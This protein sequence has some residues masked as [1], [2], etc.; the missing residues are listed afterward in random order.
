MRKTFN[1]VPMSFILI[2][3]SIA[4]SACGGGQPL[5]PTLT[6]THTPTATIDVSATSIAATGTAEIS[7]T[8]AAKTQDADI[9][10]MHATATMEAFLTTEQPKKDII[11]AAE[12]ICR[13]GTGFP[14][15]AKYTAKG[16]F[17]PL[18]LFPDMYTYPQEVR[19]ESLNE[20]E[21][22]ACIDESEETIGRRE[23]TV[24][25]LGEYYC[26]NIVQLVTITIRAAQ[27]GEVVHEYEIRGPIPTNSCGL[28]ET[29]LVGQKTIRRRGG[30][31][32]FAQIWNKLNNLVLLNVN[33]MVTPIPG[34]IS[35][36]QIS[37]GSSPPS[38]D[39]IGQIWISPLDGMELSC[40]PAGEFEMGSTKANR[41]SYLDDELPQHTVYLDAYWID[42]AEVTN[43]MF[44]QFL[45]EEGNQSE[46][47][48]T[49]LDASDKDA[50]LE[51][52]GSEWQ[53]VS[54]FGEH[55]V[56]WV[57]WYG[58]QAYCRWAERRLPRE[59]EWEKAARGTDE[60]TYPWGEGLEGAIAN[61]SYI[62][63]DTEQVGSFPDGVSPY[64]VLDMAGNV[65]EWVADWYEVYP[66]GDL[67]AIDPQYSVRFGQEYRVLRGGSWSVKAFMIRTANRY[68]APPGS[69]WSGSGFR[70]ARSP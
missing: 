10:A 11:N 25:S 47:G 9:K 13:Y 37:T 4:L 12:K 44:A 27:T 59:A 21:L 23:Y 18:V 14:G 3:I 52:S 36:P 43:A 34:A 1:I 42:R 67:D 26:L 68:S 33:G 53:P 49:W 58:A 54:G 32:D 63:G 17:H 39:E 35:T 20:L 62:F 46:G 6:T 2:V 31:P 65:W 22:V 28:S 41:N 64:G 50:H 24:D 66:G 57:T 7:I 19:P 8:S 60:R 38:C 15:V 16:D 51:Q 5:G 40:V 56:N 55:P 30:D 61:Y 29:F 69:A 48:A 70:C 45:N